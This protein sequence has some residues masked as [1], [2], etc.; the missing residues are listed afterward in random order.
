M[1][2]KV[3]VSAEV[4][5]TKNGAGTR[6]RSGM[7][8]SR[9]WLYLD[10]VPKAVEADAHLEVKKATRAEVDAASRGEDQLSLDEEPTAKKTS[11]KKSIKPE[12]IQ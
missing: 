1:P 6:K 9:E 3:R 5:Q 8:F 2:Y 4:A 10:E 12:R 11:K 7:T